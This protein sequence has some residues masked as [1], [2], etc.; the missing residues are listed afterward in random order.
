MLLRMFQT[1]RALLSR[2][3]SGRNGR[4]LDHPGFG[5]DGAGVRVP[6]RTPVLAGSA[7]RAYPPGDED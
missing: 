1:L 6:P 7:A 4:G 3:L 2:L 5:S